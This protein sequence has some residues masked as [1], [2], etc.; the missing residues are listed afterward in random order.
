MNR[1]PLSG[2]QQIVSAAAW[3]I[4]AGLLGRALGLVATLL[5][6]RH[7]SPDIVGEVAVA[8]IIALTANWI[9]AWGCGQYVIVHGGQGRPAIFAA[10]VVYLSFGIL[11]LAAVWVA[12]PLI[13]HLLGAPRLSDYLPGALL[14]MA[15]RR[16]G[17]IPDKLLARELRFRRIA[18]ATG[19]G[20][21]VY[22]V[23]AIVLVSTTA[24][25]GQSMIV[26]FIVQACTISTILISGTGLRSWLSPVPVTLE[27]LRHLFRFG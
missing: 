19:M 20:D 16:V 10:S 4:G 27:R 22:A 13:S 2:N 5:I 23:V 24:L 3:S 12:T 25:G 21:I 18:I 9:S 17:A 14:G 8:T 11:L 15:I 1:E 26:A 7:L 6:A